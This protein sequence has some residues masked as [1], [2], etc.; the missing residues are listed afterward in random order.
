VTRPDLVALTD[1]G[2]VQL[3]NA[4]LVKRGLRDIA[5]GNAPALSE[6]QDGTI[7]ARF[8]DGT[9]TR[10]APGK[11]P[12][13]ASCACP[14][15]GMCRH[16][17]AL[18]LTYRHANQAAL[19]APLTAWDPGTL[20]LAAM[21][22]AL[23]ASARS[24]LVR[25]RSVAL[26][27][28]L[29][30]GPT[31]T[32]QLPMATVRFLTPNDAAYARCDCATGTGCAHV[33]LA[34]EAFRVATGAPE[35]TLGSAGVAAPT[36]DLRSGSEAVLA[37]LLSEGATAG[38]AAHGFLIDRARGIAE[39]QG[40]T[41]LVLALDALAAQIG[42]YE[43]RSA[44]YDEIELLQLATEIYARPR[45]SAA[46]AM[47]FG[48]AMET[49]MAKTRLVSLGARV[50]ARGRELQAYV[51]LFDT[52]TGTPVLI[53]KVFAPAATEIRP[54]PAD[55]M[56]RPMAPGLPLKS[57]AGGQV[58]T[59]VA[60][61]RADGTVRF[62]SG[63]RGKTTLMPRGALVEPP[64]PLFVTSLEVLRA[65][66][67][68]RPPAFLQP[69][70]RV[71]SLRVLAVDQV[72]GQFVEPGTQTWRAAVTLP[73][74]GG[75]LHLQRRYDAGAP[76]ALDGLGAAC[77]GTHGK[78]RH[79]AG[80][81]WIEDGEIVCDPWSIACDAFIVPDCRNAR[82][83]AEPPVS[84]LAESVDGPPAMRL[85]LAGALHAGARR[86]DAD[87]LR[88]G[89]ALARSAEATGF[90]VTAQ[91]LKHWLEA[92]SNDV[93]AFGRIAMWLAVALE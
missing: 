42:A 29:A 48:E 93:D 77:A 44:L 60:H 49:A 68:A 82:P 63:A 87:F 88:R 7:E 83:S 70:N 34:V 6:A 30:Y 37:R 76:A 81:V 47:G 20:D 1:D 11:A 54:N 41:W 15:S 24:E 61:R 74:D 86:R 45:A 57:L 43:Q 22:Q 85:F 79:V 91:R 90:A 35:A 51:A 4:G 72:V 31:P 25:L 16:R 39:A 92:A 17:V 69:R 65:E 62:G 53:E 71:A 33:V 80:L 58:L 14:A 50:L 89:Q 3:A 32:A 5:E 10:L 75:R 38:L 56:A 46:A 23:S 13:E 40:A 21:E 52:D 27:A 84:S 8:T 59:S 55:M 64:A 36:S 26:H 73:N 67:A 66:L 19:A 2:L 18:V 12:G 28:R 78:V 9:L